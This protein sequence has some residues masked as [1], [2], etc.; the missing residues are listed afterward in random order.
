MLRNNTAKILQKDRFKIITKTVPGADSKNIEY[1]LGRIVQ[2]RDMNVI[3]VKTK[4]F[5][6]SLSF[7]IIVHN[8][9]LDSNDSA[10]YLYPVTI[11]EHAN[12]FDYHS[13]LQRPIVS[14]QVNGV[15]LNMFADSVD[16]VSFISSWNV[17]TFYPNVSLQPSNINLI[18]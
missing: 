6:Q 5:Q 9:T 10:Y 14:A 3:N 12:Q 4:P 7:I 11:N 18:P 2:P 16:M 1:Q 15:T 8:S 17:N 13:L